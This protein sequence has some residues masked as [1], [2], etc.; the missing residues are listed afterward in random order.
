MHKLSLLYVTEK[1]SRG[2]TKE[3]KPF[4]IEVP[5]R[6]DRGAIIGSPRQEGGNGK[7]GK[8]SIQHTLQTKKKKLDEGWVEQPFLKQFPA[9]RRPECSSSNTSRGAGTSQ[10]S[11]GAK[12]REFWR[13]LHRNARLSPSMR[14]PINCNGR[15]TKDSES[16]FSSTC[17]NQPNQASP[18]IGYEIATIA[19]LIRRA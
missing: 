7:Q 12:N 3:R 10:S 4:L 18:S 8:S 17:A 19:I 6:L 16:T 11:L 9:N 13:E 15:S 14:M 2:T 5:T 1:T